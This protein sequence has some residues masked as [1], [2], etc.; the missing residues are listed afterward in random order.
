M[1]AE[2]LSGYAARCAFAQNIFFTAGSTDGPAAR[3]SARTM[4]ASRPALGLA[5]TAFGVAVVA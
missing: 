4:T 1:S 2:S 3:R 5:M